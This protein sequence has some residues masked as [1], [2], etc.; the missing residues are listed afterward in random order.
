MEIK[1][2]D[3]APNFKLPSSSGKDVQLNDYIG[4]KV[5]LYFYVKDNTS[6]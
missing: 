5:V 6:G 2:G 4:K 1:I 3:K